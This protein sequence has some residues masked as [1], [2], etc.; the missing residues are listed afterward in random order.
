MTTQP[1]DA[2]TLRKLICLTRTESHA[3]FQILVDISFHDA[4]DSYSSTQSQ[5]ISCFWH[6]KLPPLIVVFEASGHM[7]MQADIEHIVASW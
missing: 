7:Y 6:L 2:S 4:I 5:R 1:A 3:N